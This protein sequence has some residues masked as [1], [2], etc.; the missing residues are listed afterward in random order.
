M[1]SGDPG[2]TTI[3]FYGENGPE[4]MC[5]MMYNQLFISMTFCDDPRP[6]GVCRVTRPVG[7]GGGADSAPP[8]ISQTTGPISKIQTPLDSAGHEL[9]DQGRK[10]KFDLKVID[11]VTGQVKM[12]KIDILGLVALAR[13]STLLDANEDDK[14]A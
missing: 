11:D 7:G 10:F 9:T 6:V 1:A 2:S 13:K 12:L 14:S 4:N 5:H 8:E 3:K